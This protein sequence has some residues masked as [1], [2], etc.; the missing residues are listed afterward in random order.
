MLV[1]VI[2]IGWRCTPAGHEPCHLLFN[3]EQ[4]FGASRSH[5]GGPMDRRRDRM[6]DQNQWFG[7][8]LSTTVISLMLW[9]VEI[10]LF[11]NYFGGLL[12]LANIFQHVHC[13]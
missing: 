7:G 8:T 5:R 6:L 3:F 12:Q 1:V 9:N 13:H 2:C 10:K 4:L 11:Q